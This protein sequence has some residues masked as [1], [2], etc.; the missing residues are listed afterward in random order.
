MSNPFGSIISNLIPLIAI[1]AIGFIALMVVKFLLPSHKKSTQNKT[2][3]P[4]SKEKI[5]REIL[6]EYT[7]KKYFLSLAEKK[8]F[9]L[10]QPLISNQGWYLSINVRMEDI[11]ENTRNI[12]S[13]SLIGMKHIDFLIFDRESH[14]QYAIE[15][16]GPSHQTKKQQQYDH[17]KNTV[18]EAAGLPLIRFQNGD[19][20]TAPN[21][22]EKLEQWG[23]Q[24]QSTKNKK[25][26]A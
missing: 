13:K 11:F 3:T 26:S 12:E 9:H 17:E 15:L 21:I 4:A 2:P 8:F 23:K 16:D 1:F 7:T 25:V 14:M 5:P 22:Q 19:V 24:T 6:L 20:P 18:F 10:L